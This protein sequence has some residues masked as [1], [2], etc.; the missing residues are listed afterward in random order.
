[1]TFPMR[2][3][4]VFEAQQS[5]LACGSGATEQNESF[6]LFIRCNARNSVTTFHF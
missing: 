4:I 3:G 2:K 6:V 1:M 5:A